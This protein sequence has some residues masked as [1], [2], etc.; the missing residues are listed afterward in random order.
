MALCLSV[1]MMF[2]HE[3][4]STKVAAPVGSLTDILL[5]QLSQSCREA[6]H[7]TC[8]CLLPRTSEVFSSGDPLEAWPNRS[9]D[10]SGTCLVVAGLSA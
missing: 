3:V 7:H 9:A 4:V 6:A 1:T 10:G 8:N 5:Q 2:L